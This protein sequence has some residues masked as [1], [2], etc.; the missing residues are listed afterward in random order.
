MSHTIAIIE[1]NIISTNTVR[2]KLTRTLMENGYNVVVLTS[3]TEYQMNL[4]RK[5]GFNVIDVDT[6]NQHPIDI[7]RYIRNLHRA[8]KQ[9]Q[10]DVCLTFTMRPA[11]WGN[12]VTRKL[13]IPTITNITG[14]GPLFNSYNPTYLIAQILYKIF[15][16]KTAKVFFQNQDD[17]QL[18]VRNKLIQ[19]AV[20]QLVPGSGIDYE[21]FKPMEA[22]K[23]NE[24]FVFLYIGRLLRDKGVGEYVKAARL[25]KQ[26]GYPVECRIVGP[27]WNQNLKTNTITKKE[28]DTWVKDR[29]IV[30]YG[31][32]IDVRSHIAA[33]DCIVLPSYREGASNVLLEA[34]SMERP[35]ITCDT[36]GCREI[37]SD[38]ETGLL[39]KVADAEDLANKMKQMLQLSPEQRRQMGVLGRQK[40]VKEFDK[41]FIIDTYQAA[42]QQLVQ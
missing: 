9:S 8:L 39:C 13:S 11:I 1:N 12:C 34:S 3:G 17:L 26:Q 37:V 14:I 22:P 30:Y 25:L 31:E 18:F 15:L 42:I 27:M 4:A 33:C 28:L 35:S 16:R 21:F 20:A 32:V 41:K 2:K 29:I 40:V 5:N 7:F 10:A 23:K 6:S 38:G 24:S 19:P 36:T